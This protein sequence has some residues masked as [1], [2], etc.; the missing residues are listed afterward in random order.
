MLEGNLESSILHFQV[1]KLSYQS[2]SDFFKVKQPPGRVSSER[3]CYH[4]TTIYLTSIHICWR[5]GSVFLEFI[6]TYI[7]K[8][9]SGQIIP[10]NM[11]SEQQSIGLTLIISSHRKSLCWCLNTFQSLGSGRKGLKKQTNLSHAV[12]GHLLWNG[13]L[14]CL[15]INMCLSIPGLLN[16][17]AC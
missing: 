6:D 7:Y 16:H 1:I 11:S 4:S 17:L 5:S 8:A 15:I 9:G 3:Q 13:T 10:C 12:K 2:C 14:E